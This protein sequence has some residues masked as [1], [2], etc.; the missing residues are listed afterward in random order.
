VA[1]TYK[2]KRTPTS[3]RNNDVAFIVSVVYRF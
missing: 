3:R 1:D 2:T